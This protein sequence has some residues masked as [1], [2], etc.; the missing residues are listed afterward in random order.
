VT[1]G[2]TSYTAPVI[3]AGLAPEPVTPGSTIVTGSDGADYERTVYADGAIRYKPVY[4]DL[5]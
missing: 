1:I 5:P 3:S 4:S 2:G